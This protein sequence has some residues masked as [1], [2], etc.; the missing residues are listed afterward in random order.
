LKLTNSGEAPGRVHW[1][2]LNEKPADMNHVIQ[3]TT[4]LFHELFVIQF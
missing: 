1:R 4:L 2:K 3:Q